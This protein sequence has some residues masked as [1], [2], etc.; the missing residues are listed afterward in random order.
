MSA[1][2]R[3]VI[4]GGGFGGLS[5]AR[6]LK[7]ADARILLIDKQNHHLFQPLLYQVATAALSP[8]DIAWPIRRILRRQRN[9]EVLMATVTGVDLAEK[10]V[11]V[12]RGDEPFD[13][14]VL[15]SGATHS[16]FGHDEWAPHA[17]GLKE[18]VDA[19]RI[20]RRILM[21]FELAEAVNDADGRQKF[22]TF[23]I[24]G[25][26]PTG[27]EMAGTMSELARKALAADFRNVDLR[28]AR[29]ILIEAGPRLLSSFP[30]TLSEYAL[31]ALN[32]LGVE[33]RL[34]VSVTRCDADG[35]ETG[36]GRIDAGTV[37]WAAGVEASPVARWLDVPAD[38]AGRIAVG[39]DFS[40]PGLEGVFVIGDAALYTHDE[41]ASGRALPGVAPVAKQEGTYVGTLIASRVAGKVPPS[42]F[43]YRD[44]GQLATIGRRAAVVD[45]GRIRFTGRLAWWFWGI[46]H[47]YFLISVRSRLVVAIQW[48]WSY[49]T[50]DRGA[51]LITPDS[52]PAPVETRSPHS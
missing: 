15:A 34:G 49:L 31:D 48:L 41:Q 22:L 38:R 14:L 29:V 13:Y 37:I 7:G 20:R 32:K 1:T 28:N 30:E 24:V 4:V 46:V 9:A 51:R 3:I 44:A 47:I 17:P 42:R 6:A 5:A 16:Y 36:S 25:G 8:A 45:F 27:V 50:F 19:T 40:V 12:D 21:A 26:G 10:R 11:L 33:V 23:V 39:A 35:V 43:R 18:I 52:A 2:P